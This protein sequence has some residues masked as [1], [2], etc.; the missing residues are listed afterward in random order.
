MSSKQ[1]VNAGHDTDLPPQV[2]GESARTISV[3]PRTEIFLVCQSDPVSFSDLR[4]LVDADPR[5]LAVHDEYSL[6][7]MSYLGWE[8]PLPSEIWDYVATRAIS[9]LDSLENKVDMIMA[10]IRARCRGMD[11]CTLKTVVKETL[12]YMHDDMIP[13]AYLFHDFIREKLDDVILSVMEVSPRLVQWEDH[14]G[15]LAL[16]VA[17]L[18]GSSLKIVRALV[19]AHPAALDHQDHKGNT[20]L[21]LCFQSANGGF[22]RTCSLEVVR[23]LIE[24]D[25]SALLE[26][27]LTELL[28]IHLACKSGVGLDCIQL[29]CTSLMMTL[30]SRCEEGRVP[31]HYACTVKDNASV[32]RYLVNLDEAAVYKA[33]EHGDLPLHLLLR[34]DWSMDPEEQLRLVDLFL[35]IY[36][37]GIHRFNDSHGLPLHV[38]CQ[39]SSSLE[40]IKRLVEVGDERQPLHWYSENCKQYGTVGVMNDNERFPLHLACMN[41]K[42]NLDIIEYI[43]DRYPTCV[44]HWDED[45]NLPLHYFMNSFWKKDEHEKRANLMKKMVAYFPDSVNQTGDG[46]ES[47]YSLACLWQAP[48]EIV[49]ALRGGQSPFHWRCNDGVDTPSDGSW[50]SITR[51]LSLY[52]NAIYECNEMGEL[53]LHAVCHRIRPLSA[54]QTMYKR[55]PRAIS[56]RDKHGNMPLH[57]ACYFPKKENLAFLL[58]KYKSALRIPN[59]HGELP[60][61]LVCSSGFASPGPIKLLA[62]KNPFALKRPDQNGCLPLHR[63]C[64]ADPC[65]SILLYLIRQSPSSCCVMDLHGNLPLHLLAKNPRVSSRSKIIQ[66]LT[67]RNKRALTSRNLAGFLP[68]HLYLQHRRDHSLVHVKCLAKRVFSDLS[69]ESQRSSCG[70]TFLHFACASKAK[71]EVI[72]YLLQQD[73]SNACKVLDS[74]GR[75]PLHYVQDSD[76]VH[77]IFSRFPDGTNWRDNDGNTPLHVACL[78]GR[79]VGVIQVLW[80]CGIESPLITNN[81]GDLPLHLACEAQADG[82]VMECLI[83]AYPDAV[84]KRGSCGQLPLHSWFRNVNRV[85]HRAGNEGLERVL[86]KSKDA[87]F[88]RDDEGFYPIQLAA[89][90]MD[91]DFIFRLLRSCPAVVGSCHSCQPNGGV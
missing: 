21:H 70:S 82:D 64:G 55:C 5:L 66:N 83:S 36:R 35:S 57:H 84:C 10:L 44:K 13:I 24:Q 40:L 41:R 72:Q 78:N 71:N 4:R 48:P 80:F 60:M 85:E 74:R 19:E 20:A 79:S 12:S 11:L 91:L 87:L 69:L 77:H 27:N 59:F 67:N 76:T 86:E 89:L 37:E 33:D 46:L 42:K 65:P 18:Y 39:Q 58:Q 52:P 47:A 34:Q 7:P 9:V 88:S 31:L 53:P 75:L 54:V 6:S 51:V 50:I 16:H 8:A 49:E 45:C 32:I 62:E 63:Y 15:G 17:C 3:D 26:E 38:A 29:L 28:P 30:E 56:T 23:Y 81:D 73:T 2:A 90:T 25:L 22:K 68:L 43:L 1:P 61:H 14:V